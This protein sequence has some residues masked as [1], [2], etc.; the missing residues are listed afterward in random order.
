MTAKLGGARARDLV[1]PAARQGGRV[2]A[3]DAAGVAERGGS[4]GAAQAGRTEPGGR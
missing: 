4:R 3:G 1:L 2:A